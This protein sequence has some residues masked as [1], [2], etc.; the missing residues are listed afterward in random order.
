[1][2]MQTIMQKSH[3]KLYAI[4]MLLCAIIKGAE[5]D[6]LMQRAIATPE[7]LRARSIQIE[8]IMDAQNNTE[9]R[10]RVSL[11]EIHNQMEYLQTEHDNLCFDLNRIALDKR[12]IDR[13]IG[14]LKSQADAQGYRPNRYDFDHQ[15]DG[16][17]CCF[18]TYKATKSLIND[19]HCKTRQSKRVEKYKS[20]IHFVCMGCCISLSAA[21]L[22]RSIHNS[23]ENTILQEKEYK[24][25]NKLV[26]D[27][28]FVESFNFAP[29][30]CMIA[31]T[32]SGIN[33]KEWAII[34]NNILEEKFKKSNLPK[35][36][37]PN[38]SYP[39]VPYQKP[40]YVKWQAGKYRQCKQKNE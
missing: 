16:Q 2:T 18:L 11:T 7:S 6:P 37:N 38:F 4:V 1:M 35:S 23:A 32:Y 12:N 17:S 3:K 27:H 5:Q 19:F 20:E 36:T 24:R 13:I 39:I 33:R 31:S 15:D 30:E 28:C 34:H 21:L 26:Y 29:Q 9:I 40:E 25:L 14:L 8:R 22:M 10:P